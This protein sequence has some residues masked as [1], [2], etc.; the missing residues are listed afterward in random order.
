MAVST[1]DELAEYLSGCAVSGVVDVDNASCE[2]L[3]SILIDSFAVALAALKHPAALAARRYASTCK[4]RL[5]CA[6]RLRPPWE[7]PTY[8]PPDST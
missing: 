2:R 1:T 4:I 5:C 6:D 8:K 7:K 3:K